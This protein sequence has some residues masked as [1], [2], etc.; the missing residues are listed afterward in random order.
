MTFFRRDGPVIVI[1]SLQ[2]GGPIRVIDEDGQELAS[3]SPFWE[4][5]EGSCGQEYAY[6]HLCRE[7][8]LCGLCHP[9]L[10]DVSAP[11]G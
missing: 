4:R 8:M 7:H 11:E 1:P 3:G 6:P 2:P 5:C 9:P 10:S